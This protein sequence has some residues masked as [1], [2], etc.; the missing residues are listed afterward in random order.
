MQCTINSL[1]EDL[2]ERIDDVYEV[3]KNFFGEENVDLQNKQSE[4]D[5]KDYIRR[6]LCRTFS[7][8]EFCHKKDEESFT[9]NK[10]HI[11]SLIENF[12]PCN[13]YVYWPKVTVTNEHDKSIDI[14]DL[15]AKIVV[16]VAGTIPYEEVGFKLNRATYTEEQFGSSYL[17]S[18][19]QN[20]PYDNYTKFMVPCLGNGPIK[21]TIDSL[22]T[23]YD[24]ALWMLFCQ[25]LSMYVTVES[26]KGVPWKRLEEVTNKSK[27]SISVTYEKQLSIYNFTDILPSGTLITFISY[28]LKHGHLTFS[29]DGYRFVPGMDAIH[30]LID[31]TNCFI[32]CVNTGKIVL[33][34]DLKKLIRKAVLKE[35][36]ILDNE[37]YVFNNTTN[38]HDISECI[39]QPVLTFKGKQVTLNILKEEEKERTESLLLNTKIANYIMDK[40]LNIINYRYVNEYNR[41]QHSD[42]TSPVGKK[43][44]YL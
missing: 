36:A 32:E 22:K 17:H 33:E 42:R 21:S 3:F 43:V 40:V 28:Y 23:E 25:E 27:E 6:F 39:G 12:K 9:L 20:I 26:L 41:F 31:L 7:P 5:C 35:V 30:Y 37:V 8:T 18:H 29:Y 11:Q 15:Y 24:E 19:I 4:K 14:Q 38:I 2:Y 34:G 10:E 13:I 16:N 44:L 1:Y